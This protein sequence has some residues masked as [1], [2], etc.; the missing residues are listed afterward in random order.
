MRSF[1]PALFLLLSLSATAQSITPPDG[2]KQQV[3]GDRYIFTPNTI[4]QNNF[5]YEVMPP[6][7]NID[8]ELV[9][10]LDKTAGN[11]IQEAGYSIPTSTSPQRKTVQAMNIYGTYAKDKVGNTKNFFLLA[12]RKPDNTVRYARIIY[13]GNPKNTNLNIAVNHFAALAKKEGAAVSSGNT[14]SGNNNKQNETTPR[15]QSTPTT[16]PGQGLK[17]GEIKGVVINAESGIGV[18]GMVTIEYRP[19]LLLQ[20]GTVYRYPTVAPY[21]LDVAASKTAEPNK[22]GTWKLDGKTLVVTLPEKGVMKTERWTSEWFWAK[23]PTA[24]EKIK[25]AFMTIGG[26]GNTAMGGNTMI[27]YSS[28]I[29]FNDKGQFIMKKSGGG[30]NTDFDV[31]TTAYSNSNA[32]GTYKLNGYS[33][34]MKYNNGQVVRKLF[35]FYPDSRTTF[36]IGDD[37]YVPD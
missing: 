3:Q 33:I 25:G 4:F 26:G 17:P 8:G 32:A 24:N 28:N 18:G 35:Y 10:W 37:A 21:D 16:A 6:E 20:N 30:T 1:L 29:N 36:G 31:N 27:Y 11:T 9:D 2:W 12:Y 15:K 14:V 19:Y 13:P 23:A 34:E 5:T 22:W 7:K